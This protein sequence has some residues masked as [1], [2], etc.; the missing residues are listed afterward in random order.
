MKFLLALMVTL[1][2]S[3]ALGVGILFAV[4]GRWWFLIAVSAA[5]LLAFA[6]LG[7]LPRSSH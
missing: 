7:C 4:R 5:Y 2:M 3:A 6:R 1:A